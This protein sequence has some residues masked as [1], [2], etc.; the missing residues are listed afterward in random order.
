MLWLFWLNA[1][2]KAGFSWTVSW[3]VDIIL[4]CWAGFHFKEATYCRPSLQ[5]LEAFN[6]LFWN[7]SSLTHYSCMELIP[8]LDYAPLGLLFKSML[9][10]FYSQDSYRDK[11]TSH[12]PPYIPTYLSLL[13]KNRLSAIISLHFHIFTQNYAKLAFPKGMIIMIYS[14]CF[15]NKEVNC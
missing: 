10:K 11:L 1:R 12:W 7:G 5:W 8:E 9:F 15:T 13:T 3:L 14:L 2:Q 6:K 4:L